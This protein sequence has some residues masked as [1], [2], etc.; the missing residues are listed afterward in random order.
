MGGD[1]RT[2]PFGEE[3]PNVDSMQVF[4]VSSEAIS[5]DR[6]P[7][8]A[9][10]RLSA[11]AAARAFRPLRRLAAALGAVDRLS[12]G[13]LAALALVTLVRAPE[14]LPLLLGLGAIAGGV[15][16]VATVAHRSSALTATHDFLP[17]ITTVA[18]FELLGRIIPAVHPARWDPTFA[19][20]DERWFG[21]LRVAWVGLL[22]RPSWLTDLASAAYVAYYP[23][24]V[25][26]GVV[27][28]RRRTP[29]VFARYVFTVVASFYASYTGYLL[30][31]TLG[32]RTDDVALLGGGALSEAVRTFVRL[33]EGNP[34]DAFPSGHTAVSLICLR[35]GWYHLPAWR[36]PLV[37]LVAGIV[38]ATVYLSYH[39]VVDLV[40]GVLLAAAVSALLPP[41]RRWSRPPQRPS[42]VTTQRSPLRAMRSNR[43]AR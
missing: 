22:G 12:L 16:L 28:Y 29:D 7:R 9:L 21:D 36:I 19:V 40:A 20:L 30:F 6:D 4:G 11:I 17:I 1:Y 34:L 33:A 23:L 10:P 18:I 39:Y 31:P 42:S 24:P 2:R 5:A 27:L 15:T 43:L 26:I 37:V 32:P 8:V 13:F 3:R 38:F 25:V 41:D 35:L 14:P